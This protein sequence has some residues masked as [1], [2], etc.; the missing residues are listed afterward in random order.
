MTDIND[1]LKTAWIRQLNEDW[2]TANFLYFKDSM[3]PPNFELSYSEVAL[4][5]WKG[6]CHRHLSI[7]INLI[8]TYAW[9]YVQEVLYHEMAHQYV[10]EVLGICEV[11][12]LIQRLRVTFKP[13]WKNAKTD[14]P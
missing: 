12:G 14:S 3:R 9:E 7:S 1:K 11:R 10:E 6:G 5:R 4:G 8:K 13:G 2:K